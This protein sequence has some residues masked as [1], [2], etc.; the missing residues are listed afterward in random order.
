MFYLSN[1]Q[2]K[3]QK[4][5]NVCGRNLI[6]ILADE[7]LEEHR[8]DI[9]QIEK[10]Y[11]NILGHKILKLNTAADIN[12]DVYKS[13]NQDI[14][15]IRDNMTLKSITIFNLLSVS[16]N[17]KDLIETLINHFRSSY[18]IDETGDRKFKKRDLPSILFNFSCGK[19]KS[20]F[21]YN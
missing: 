6:I 13:E 17:I 21:S 15:M 8:S 2:K 1:F 11:K 18:T 14:D 3:N 7:R 5:I 20:S 9:K 4:A 19:L 16:E 10:F 12:I